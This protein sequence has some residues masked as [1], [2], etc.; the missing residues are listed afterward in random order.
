MGKKEE[1][2]DRKRQA[3]ELIQEAL[4]C[5]YR[6]TLINT[7]LLQELVRDLEEAQEY[8]DRMDPTICWGG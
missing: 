1:I 6:S 2:A 8:I 3:E 4:D 5:G 7:A